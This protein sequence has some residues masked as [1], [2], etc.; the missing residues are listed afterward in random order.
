MSRK[1]RFLKNKF[2][3]LVCMLVGTFTAGAY[4]FVVDGIYYNKNGNEATVTY[5]DA[6][7]NTYKGE[8][9]IPS[10]VTYGGE[11]LTV[12]AIGD[13]A[14]KSCTGLTSVT[15]PNTVNALGASSFRG[16]NGLTNIT[17]PQSVTTIGAEAFY[18]CTHLTSM[19][20]PN[21][22][23]SIGN[24]SFYNCTSLASITIPNSVIYL[25]SYAFY[26]C[27]RLA[28]VTIPSSITAI[29]GYLFYGCTG[30]TYV[31]IPNTVTSIGQ[32]SFSG[33]TGLTQITIPN[34]VLSKTI[35][36]LFGSNEDHRLRIMAVL[37][38]GMNLD[39]FKKDLDE[40]MFSYDW[41]NN[42]KTTFLS[43]GYSE[44][45]PKVEVSYWIT[46]YEYIDCGKIRIL[47]NIN[48]LADEYRKN[49]PMDYY[50]NS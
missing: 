11:T 22:V 31:A 47:E 3:L 39:D 15:I 8:V 43:Y 1:T 5:K 24:Y 34:S 30:L 21:S 13:N 6:G 19:E 35:Y 20:I 28:S 27:T 2:V 44:W 32:Y 40:I 9:T 42:N 29:N 50:N 12:I 10:T 41:V 16:C 4:N 17:L 45:G 23:T 38:H 25:G 46:K 7:Y 37:P 49:N 14:F 36:K 18:G 48:S 33:C 26:G